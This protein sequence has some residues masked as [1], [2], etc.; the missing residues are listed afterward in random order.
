M[1]KENVIKSMMKT[2]LDVFGRSELIEIG[3]HVLNNDSHIDEI[4]P[5]LLTKD[6]TIRE[7]FQTMVRNFMKER[8][9]NEKVADMLEDLGSGYVIFNVLNDLHIIDEVV[10]ELEGE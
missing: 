6:E 8:I 4:V 2:N 1:S 5:V 9:S 10:E 7:E 3:L